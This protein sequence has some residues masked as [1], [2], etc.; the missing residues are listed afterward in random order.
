MAD[1]LADKPAPRIGLF[2]TC[3]VDSDPADASASPPSSCSRR[4]A[5]Q[6]RCRR[7]RPAAASRPTTWRPGTTAGHRRRS[8]RPSRLRLCRG[9][10]GLLRRHDQAGTIPR[11]F[12]D[13]PAWRARA[14]ALG[15]KTHELV[16]VSGRH[17]RL[18][19][20]VGARSPA[21]S[22]I[23]TL[24]RACASSDPGQPRKLL[25]ADRWSRNE[26]K[27][28]SADVCCGFGGTFC[29]KYP[30]IS[31]AIVEEKAA[32]SSRRAPTRC[33]PAISGAS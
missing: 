10:V 3:L 11:L 1:A 31:N 27:C 8:S 22:P 14:E 24:A 30:D 18:S 16:S 13:D 15:G 25:A 20:K 17:A 29:V 21:R 19:T 2:V 23:T 5:A 28:S 9:A 12:D 32:A 6:S 33:S 4:P 7:R 26:S